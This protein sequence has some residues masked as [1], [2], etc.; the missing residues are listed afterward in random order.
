MIGM[1]MA[2]RPNKNKGFTNCIKVL[3]EIYLINAGKFNYYPLN[4]F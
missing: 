4:N 1:A 3:D 2:N